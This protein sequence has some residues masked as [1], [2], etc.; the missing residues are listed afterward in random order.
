MDP[1]V[2]IGL[3]AAFEFEPAAGQGVSGGRKGK[4]G[5]EI[6]EPDLF[7]VVNNI[8]CMQFHSLR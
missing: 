1:G 7:V 3:A 6:E 4:I 8:C 2:E 5:A